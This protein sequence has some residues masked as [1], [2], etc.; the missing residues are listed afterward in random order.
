[1]AQTKPL[2]WSCASLRS[3]TYVLALDLVAAMS[4]ILII[5]QS[6]YNIG[7][8]KMIA[9]YTKA[10]YHAHKFTCVLSNPPD[11]ITYVRVSFRF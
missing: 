11:K 8:G 4:S 10:V 6:K 3:G 1:M 5:P 9:H 2:L 7:S